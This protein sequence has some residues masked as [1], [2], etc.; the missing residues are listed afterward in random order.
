[1]SL[2]PPLK[3]LTDLEDLEIIA[4]GSYSTVYAFN[5]QDQDSVLRLTRVQHNFHHEE[6]IW[7]LLSPCEVPIPQNFLTGNYQEYEY[8]VSARCPGQT[9]RHPPNLA[10]L[11]PPLI[12]VM[13]RVHQAQV[14]TN[15][16]IW[17]PETDNFWYQPIC[18]QIKLNFYHYYYAQWVQQNA[19]ILTHLEMF[20]QF[21]IIWGF[22]NRYTPANELYFLHGDLC[23]NNICVDSGRIT[24]LVDWQLSTLGD[25]VFDYAYLL[26][27]SKL[28]PIDFFLQTVPQ[29]YAAQG[30]N[31]HFYA[32]RLMSNVLFQGLAYMC[33]YFQRHQDAAVNPSRI[34]QRL[35]KLWKQIHPFVLV[36]TAERQSASSGCRLP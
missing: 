15:K 13:L 27:F 6:R 20:Q 32:S 22:L 28:D 4:K 12:P 7:Q 26:L 9:Q 14:P 8:A 29:T 3:T 17:P 24:G 30:F 16:R 10:E 23:F 33:R 11:L 21:V 2:P 31:T 34:P 1:M 25:W 18:W 5:Y 36:E 35:F 19:H